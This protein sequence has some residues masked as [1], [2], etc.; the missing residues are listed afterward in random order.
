MSEGCILVVDDEPF[1]M[2][3]LISVLGD[4]GYETVSASDGGQAWEALLAD[5]ERFDAVVADRMMPNMNGMEL[6]ERIKA[7]QQ[8]AML[9]VIMQT[10]RTANEDIAEGLE[11]GAWYYL[12]KPF[13]DHTL[14]AVVRTATQEYQTYRAVVKEAAGSAR[15]L[16]FLN[17]GVFTFR[18]VDEARDLASLLS[19]TVENGDRLAIGLIELFLNAVEHGNLGIGYQAKSMLNQTGDW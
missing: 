19:N 18:T 12:C 7:N 1:N 15:C 16:R 14:L 17:Q 6:L 10:A 13:D 5:P 9:P 4:A 3:I 2:D 8:F 11:A